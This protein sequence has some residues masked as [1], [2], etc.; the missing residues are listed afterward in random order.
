MKGIVFTQFL[1]MVEEVCSI[2]VAEQIVERSDL[3]SGGAYTAVGTYDHG[4]IVQLVKQLGLITNT[5]EAE[6]LRAF[7][8]YLFPQFFIAYPRL[9]DGVHSTLEFL[10]R[11]EDYI[12]VEVLKLYPDAELP[13]FQVSSSQPGHL[14]MVYRSRHPLADLAEGLIAGCAEHFGEEVSIERTELCDERGPA[15]RFSLRVK[16]GVPQC[17]T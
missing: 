7:G 9:F 5:P 2:D 4:E 6:L 15:V 16:A 14:E 11:V 12:H 3:P 17:S 8:K 1:E 13:R 10:S